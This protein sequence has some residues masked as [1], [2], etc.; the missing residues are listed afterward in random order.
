MKPTVL[1]ITTG[2]TI[3]EVQPAGQTNDATVGRFD[4]ARGRLEATIGGD[5]LVSRLPGV[6]QLADLQIERFAALD[7]FQI[8]LD[9]VFSIAR[10]IDEVLARDE[11]SGAVVTHGTDTLEETCFLV[12]LLVH[13]DKPVVFT[14]AQIPGG[15]ADSDGPR[16]LLDSIRVAVSSKARGLGAM[17]CFN[18][19]LHAARDV[20]KTH[21]TAVQTYQSYGHGPIGVVDG[22]QVVVQRRPLL[23]RQ[24]SV[25]RLERRVDLIRIALDV[26]GSQIDAAVSKGVKGLVIEALGL[27]NVPPVVVASVRGAIAAGVVVVITSRCLAGRAAPVFAGDGCGKDLADAGAMFA[28][29]LAGIKARLLLMVALADPKTCEQLPQILAEIAP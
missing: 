19:E 20:S 15:D 4:P 24:F 8:T 10:R 5:D 13:S 2:G 1:I 7:G 23:R 27:G 11:V 22:Q 28:G 29:D 14:G 12:E 21:T 26:D 17:I 16:N 25:T 18:G 9:T 3:A 6:A